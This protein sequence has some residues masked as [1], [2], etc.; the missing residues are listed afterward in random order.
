VIDFY[1]TGNY[2]VVMADA[3]NVAPAIDGRNPTVQ[4]ATDKLTQLAARGATI[5]SSDWTNPA[6]TSLTTPRS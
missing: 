6:I 4:Q 2:L 3:Q 1:K 5:I